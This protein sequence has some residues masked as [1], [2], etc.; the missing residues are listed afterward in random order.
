MDDSFATESV[1][2]RHRLVVLSYFCVLV[3]K[4]GRVAWLADEEDAVDDSFALSF[5]ACNTRVLKCESKLDVFP[6]LARTLLL[7]WRHT[8]TP[9]STIFPSPLTLV[10]PYRGHNFFLRN[11]LRLFLHIKLLT[12]HHVMYTNA[13]AMYRYSGKHYRYAS[14]IEIN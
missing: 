1:I 12:L 13:C 8:A 2:S 10:I 5:W 7:H 14:E 6:P 11:D 4:S 9:S 3:N